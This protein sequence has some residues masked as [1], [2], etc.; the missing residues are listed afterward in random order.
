MRYGST[1]YFRRLVR[2][3]YDHTTG[4]YLPDTAEETPVDANITDAGTQT[5]RLVYGDIRQGV[6]V[7]RILRGYDGI[8]DDIRIGTKIYRV[9]MKRI[10]GGIETYVVSEVQ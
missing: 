6:K 2:G 10:V 4:N 7:L 5:L 8:F 3:A 9:D 1:V